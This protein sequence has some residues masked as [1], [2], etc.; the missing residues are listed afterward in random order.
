MTRLY[1]AL[2]LT[3]GTFAATAGAASGQ[4][5]PKAGRCTP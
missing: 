3:I 5:Q 1:L 4:Q 2:F